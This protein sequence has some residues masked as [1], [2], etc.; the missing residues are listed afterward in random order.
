[1]SSTITNEHP[2][3][4][5]LEEHTDDPAMLAALRRGLGQIPGA[6]PATYRYIAPFLNTGK[7]TDLF[8]IAS[9]FA[10]HPASDAEGNMGAHMRELCSTRSKNA[11]E[12]HFLQL[13]DVRRDSLETSLWRAK[14]ILKSHDIPVNWHQLMYDV[15]RWDHPDHYVQRYWAPAQS[16]TK[17]ASRKEKSQ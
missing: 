17:S 4:R 3:I 11:T 10:L 7:E 16:K 6:V 5:Y 2:L 13:L 1:M 14:S 8:L 9:L 15:R 12:N